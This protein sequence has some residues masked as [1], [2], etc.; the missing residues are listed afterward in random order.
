MGCIMTDI[1]PA[2][3]RFDYAGL[4]RPNLPAAGAPASVPP[5]ISVVTAEPRPDDAELLHSSNGRAEWIAAELVKAGAAFDGK[6]HLPQTKTRPRRPEPVEPITLSA[7][8]A[9]VVDH[10]ARDCRASRRSASRRRSCSP[11]SRAAR[12]RRRSCSSSRARADHAHG[13]VLL[14]GRREGLP[15]GVG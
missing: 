11:R 13:L 6:V 15:R 7:L 12:T 4:A 8:K 2:R 9:I 3:S 14:V 1:A 10:A 5:F